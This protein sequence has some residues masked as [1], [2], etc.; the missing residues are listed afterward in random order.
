MTRN[1]PDQLSLHRRTVPVIP[2][3][4]IQYSP[5][6]IKLI[7]RTFLT[8][9]IPILVVFWNM[10]FTT[11]FNTY[12]AKFLKWNNTPYIFSTVHYHFRDI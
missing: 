9:N 12:H 8:I 5:L 11:Y 2:G 7:G 1:V 6:Y 4:Q 3:L 10:F